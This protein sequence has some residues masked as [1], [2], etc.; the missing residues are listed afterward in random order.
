MVKEQRDIPMVDLTSQY[1]RL[2][3]G[4]DEAMSGVLTRGDYINGS[5][6]KSFSNALAGYLGTGYV[7]PCANGTDALQAALMAL[8]L[9][10]GDE[11]I[12]TSFSFI[13][14]VEVI[15]LLGLRP[16]LVD[17]NPDTLNIDPDAV[18]DAITGRTRV[19]LPVHLFGQ[20]A[21][22]SEIMEIARLHNLFVIEDA[23]QSLGASCFMNGNETSMATIASK[24]NLNNQPCEFH[25][26]N[27]L[28]K[29]FTDEIKVGTIGHI[30]CTSF[31]PTKNLGCFGD[32]GACFT[33]DE[34]I[35]ERLRM[36]VNHGARKK[37]LNEIVGM[38]SRLDTLQAAVLS[39]KLLHLDDFIDRRRN[40]ARVYLEELKNLSGL[41]LPFPTEH[42]T[43]TF[44]QFTVRVKNDRRDMLKSFL[45]EAE[46]PSMV[47]Y[48]L[49]LH[50]QPVFKALC[51]DDLHLPESDSA[52]K[53]VLSLPMHTEMTE[54][55]QE[56]IIQKIRMF[57][58]K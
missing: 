3:P 2:K 49:P 33:D 44:N 13:S 54:T 1:Q 7:I 11:V 57:F 51:K 39:E 5:V 46:I 48:P 27:N 29:L 15:A 28:N 24:E 55:Q 18:R 17:I 21:A 19:L 37:Y 9:S 30:G 40:A 50:R 45:A 22:M 31:F 12:T 34:R 43:H 35:A 20:P 58:R 25:Q 38:N 36:I 41:G 10:P 4:I 14:T 47:Y 6:V 42:D 26:T 23:A 56:Y 53:E 32:G 52:C 8:E 16:V